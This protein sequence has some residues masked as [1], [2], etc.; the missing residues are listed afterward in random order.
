MIRPLKIIQWNSKSIKYNELS[1]YSLDNDI[2]IISETWLDFSDNIK[3]KDFDVI[4]RDRLCRRGGGVL[5]F[6]RSSLK[7]SIIE[8]VP[9][10]HGAIESCGVNVWS[11]QG[12]ISIISIYRPPD[13]PRINSRS[14]SIFFSYFK[15]NVIIGG[16]FNLPN[17]LI[18]PL[19]EGIHNLDL[20]LL[21]DSS[22]TYWN[23]DR[24][25]FSILDLTLVNSVLGLKSS[26]NVH[27]DLWGGDHFPIFIQLDVDTNRRPV[28][29]RPP[30]LYSHRTDWTLY[31]TLLRS[32]IDLFS[33]DLLNTSDV[34]SL[35]SSFT[36]II[37][38]CLRNASSSFESPSYIKNPKQN[39]S[40]PQESINNT[41]R[42]KTSSFNYSTN[43]VRSKNNPKVKN[44]KN[45]CPW[46]NSECD[47]L[48][49]NRKRALEIFKNNKSRINFL[50][51]KKEVAKTRIGLRNIKKEN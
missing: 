37:T 10:L 31:S 25:H 15:G 23:I 11:D 33:Q 16:D 9:D 35:Y 32:D 27:Q 29:S 14:W 24:G 18:I 30:K 6:V 47:L 43:S 51:Y 39:H 42:C 34:Q 19:L 45:P 36:S 4:R 12:I 46:W 5:I 17:D 1:H 26:W 38:N 20:V 21:N 2:F 8:D 7:Y 3:L 44:I 13:S 40:F 49:S 22:P 48:I 41:K 28:I 50:A